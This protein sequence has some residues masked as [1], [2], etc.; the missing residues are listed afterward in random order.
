MLVG[1]YPPSRLYVELKIKMAKKAGV[2]AHLI[3]LPEHIKQ[4]KIE[5]IVC[6]L[7]DDVTVSG[8]LIQLPL[9]KHLN[10]NALIELIPP[11]K[12]VDGL[13]AQNLGRLM[14]NEKGL[15]PCTPL[16]V[17]ELIHQYK[18]STE[19]KKAVIVGRSSL[20]SLPLAMLLSR[21]GIDCTVTLCHSRTTDLVQECQQADIL[22]A[23]C[24]SSE[25][26]TKD[27]IKA[28]AIVFDVG[29][30]RKDGTVYGDVKFDEVSKVAGAIT[31]MPGGTG[32]MTV[33]CL[34]KNTVL[35]TT[36]QSK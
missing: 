24:G 32:P 27:F 12:D 18:L 28:G 7:A 6:D 16:G 17:M 26:I 2:T 3:E 19:G 35:A 4:G 5:Q 20:V 9:P 31:P 13:T 36:I 30:T 23:A 21:K 8:I 14:N 15:I 11:V 10:T 22:V 1:N 34:I 25:M 33:A 29:V